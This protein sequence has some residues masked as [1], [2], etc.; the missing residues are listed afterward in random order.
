MMGN[1]FYSGFSWIGMGFGMVIF[2]AVFL[3]LIVFII[4]MINK[5]ESSE[6]EVSALEVLRKRYVRGDITKK[7]FK[8][9]KKVLR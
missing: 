6:K 7:K 2:W 4:K 5:D 1:G 8:E 9:M 3:G